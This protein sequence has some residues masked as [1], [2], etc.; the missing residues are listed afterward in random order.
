MLK[1]LMRFIGIHAPFQQLRIA[2]YRKAGIKIGNPLLFGGHI[3]ID[4]SYPQVTIEDNVLLGGYD[5]ILAHSHI[6]YEN[7]NAPVV[8]KKNARIGVRVTILPGVTIGE[9]S[10]IG[11]GSV[12]SESIPDNVV[13]VGVPAKAIKKI[14]KKNQNWEG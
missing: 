5:F 12:V 4:V 6:G 8:I 11:A 13:A 3:W 2:M 10:I 14:E 9:N 7:V 1:N